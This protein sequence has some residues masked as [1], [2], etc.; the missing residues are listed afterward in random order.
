MQRFFS[1][2]ERNFSEWL[3]KID[4]VPQ[5][6]DL[7]INGDFLLLA[8]L[9]SSSKKVFMSSSVSSSFY[10]SSGAAETK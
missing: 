2:S 1:G 3:L 6:M 10:C 7:A 5:A 4:R 9:G 8:L